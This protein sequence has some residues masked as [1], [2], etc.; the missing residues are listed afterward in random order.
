M[1]LMESI[2]IW[3]P[4][5]MI[6]SAMIIV[7]TRSILA[8]WAESLWWPA[9][10]SL[11]IIIM[12]EIASVKLWIASEAMASEFDKKP[13]IILKTASKK[14]TKMNKKPAL[15]IIWLRF[16]FMYLF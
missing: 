10:F 6:I 8:R 1:F 7:V 16:A 12:P 2:M 14:L 3:A 4:T 15:T 13:M 11:T 5:A 9:S